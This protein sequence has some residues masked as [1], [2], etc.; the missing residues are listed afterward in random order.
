ME[1]CSKSDN[2][3]V[4]VKHIG[5][6]YLSVVLNV[7]F[8]FGKCGYL[9]TYMPLI[10]ALRCESVSWGLQSKGADWTGRPVLQHQ[11]RL[12]A[13]MFVWFFF[14]FARVR[15]VGCGDK[16]KPNSKVARSLEGALPIK[17]TAG[18]QW[19]VR[20]GAPYFPPCRFR[21]VPVF[22]CARERKIR[23]DRVPAKQK[24]K[25]PVHNEGKKDWFLLGVILLLD[26]FCGGPSR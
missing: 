12:R 23:F 10:C 20:L 13:L 15:S 14:F 3:W 24:V 5:V 19:Q 2:C 1:V 25:V 16:R 7:S 26:S 21:P 6:C 18:V 17:E 8:D 22:W 4:E 11:P 9:P